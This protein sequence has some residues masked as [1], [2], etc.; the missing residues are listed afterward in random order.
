MIVDLSR[1]DDEDVDYRL[2]RQ[3]L[4]NRTYLAM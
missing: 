1:M 3:S 2:R 4:L